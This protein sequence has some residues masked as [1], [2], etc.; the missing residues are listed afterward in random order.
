MTENAIA[1][2]VVD[3]AFRGPGLAYDLAQGGLRTVTQQ[4]IPVIYGMI[5]EWTGGRVSRK[6][7][8][9][10]RKPVTLRDFLFEVEGLA[11]SRINFSR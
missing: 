7:A 2:E 3:A 8:R 10:P 1:K 4:A 9:T 11:R 5:I 6:V